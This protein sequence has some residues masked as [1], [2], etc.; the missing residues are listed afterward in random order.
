MRSIL[1][2]PLLGVAITVA[3]ACSSSSNARECHAGA[4]CVSGACSADG[5]CLPTGQ[6]TNDASPATP[7]AS[8]PTN[9]TDPRD[10]SVDATTNGC[11]PNHDGI[12]SRQEVPL[13]AGLHATYK[14]G[15][16]ETVSTAGV[17][18]ADGSRV[19]DFSAPLASDVS[20]IVETLPLA[21]KWYAPDFTTASYATALR[22]DSNLLGV[23]QT[24]S[25]AI[26]LLGVASPDNDASSTKLTYDPPVPVLTFPLK[27]GSA[28]TTDATVSGT[29]SGVVLF[30]T[31]TE[32]YE[33]AADA[34]G[35]LETPLGSFHVIRVGVKLTRTVG[36]L[37]T[38]YR[39]F[40]FVTECYGTVASVASDE[41]ED[42]VEFTHAAE[43][44]RIAP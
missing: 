35:E 15:H 14:I 42:N 39:T 13:Q 3:A 33:S 17:V 21:G 29:A 4:D 43:I 40:A 44:R 19:W 32:K 7:D 37:V 2:T 34:E 28:W 36:F 23:F 24:P 26:Q 38:T 9:S 31:Y 8:G 6:V 5:Q 25:A 22:N 11:V 27:K 12:I 41:N 10:A 20:V 16:A 1:I 18:Q 30:G